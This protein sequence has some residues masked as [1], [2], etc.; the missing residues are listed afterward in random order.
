VSQLGPR[1]E[2]RE[3]D[4][5]AGDSSVNARLSREATVPG[6]M[7]SCEAISATLRSAQ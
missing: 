3:A 7:S 5:D 4:V 6:G 1:R 2:L